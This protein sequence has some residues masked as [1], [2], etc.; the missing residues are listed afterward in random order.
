MQFLRSKQLCVSRV[1][2]QSRGILSSQVDI[3][4]TRTCPD[5]ACDLL[6][7]LL[8]KVVA[9]LSRQLHSWKLQ[10]KAL[11]VYILSTDRMIMGAALPSLSLCHDVSF[12]FRALRFV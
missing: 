10:D 7:E 4:L 1:V 2:G 3:L 9:K 12:E 11:P 8:D 5:H 6:G